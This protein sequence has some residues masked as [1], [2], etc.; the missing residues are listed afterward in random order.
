MQTTKQLDEFHREIRKNVQ[1]LKEKAELFEAGIKTSFWQAY[2]EMLGVMIEA[3]GAEI[4]APAGSVDGA[5]AL[6]HVKGA[7]NGLILA[8]DLPSL[9]IAQA[10]ELRGSEEEE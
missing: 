7:M 4:L 8:R 3:R 10:K 9:T 6:E 1:N 2:I 5:L